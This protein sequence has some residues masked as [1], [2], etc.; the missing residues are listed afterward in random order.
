MAKPV[1]V[2]LAVVVAKEAGSR[3]GRT[4][5][6]GAAAPSSGGQGLIAF[7][8]IAILQSGTTTVPSPP[9]RAAGRLFI[10]KTPGS[11]G[12]A[13]VDDRGEREKEGHPN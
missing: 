10:E 11:T 4:I 5:W 7:E 3:A 9:Q 8:R 1:V 6:E 13:G 12:A 2:T